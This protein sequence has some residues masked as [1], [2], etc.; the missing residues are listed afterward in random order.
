M[1]RSNGHTIYGIRYMQYMGCQIKRYTIILSLSLPLRLFFSLHTIYT[2]L[3]I[4]LGLILLVSVFG[5][6]ISAFRFD[7]FD[8]D[9]RYSVCDCLCASM[10]C[11]SNI[12]VECWIYSR[13]SIWSFS[14]CYWYIH[15]LWH[16]A[17]ESFAKK[18]SKQ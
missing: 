2:L 14:L 3:L 8:I 4:E 12:L 10:A 11:A 1:H 6:Y 18:I 13:E 15:M 17:T 16:T 5:S 9:F 7:R